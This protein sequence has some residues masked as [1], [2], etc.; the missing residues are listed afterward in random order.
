LLDAR[1]GEIVAGLIGDSRVENALKNGNAPAEAS[2]AVAEKTG[3]ISAE[4]KTA[5]L[6][7]QAA[8]R[9]LRAVAKVEFLRNIRARSSPTWSSSS[10]TSNTP[11]P[12]ISRQK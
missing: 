8:E 6:I 12:R 1:F 10:K 4:T 9:T 3:V 7:A 11:L 2:G 5:L